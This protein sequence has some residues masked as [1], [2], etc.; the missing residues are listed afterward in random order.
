[1]CLLLLMAILNNTNTV[2]IIFNINYGASSIHDICPNNN[3]HNNA[4]HQVKK[5]HNLAIHQ[6]QNIKFYIYT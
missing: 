1:M 2:F 5:G 6:K 3:N 4:H